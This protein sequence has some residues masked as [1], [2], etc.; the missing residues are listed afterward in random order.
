MVT[1]QNLL[2][3]IPFQIM[4]LFG[5]PRVQH[6]RSDSEFF[7][8][9]FFNKNGYEIILRV[10]AEPLVQVTKCPMCLWVFCLEHK[11]S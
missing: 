11:Q 5:I 10:V 2:I 8:L 4:K 6:F 9:F 7:Y 1:S 3:L